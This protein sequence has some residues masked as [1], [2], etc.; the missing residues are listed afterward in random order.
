M[1]KT[2]SRR[3]GHPTVSGFYRISFCSLTRIFQ[4]FPSGSVRFPFCSIFSAQE[5]LLVQDTVRVEM[6]WDG[7][8]DF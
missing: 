2:A 5:R 4:V 6:K 1:L 7:R 3:A 8:N